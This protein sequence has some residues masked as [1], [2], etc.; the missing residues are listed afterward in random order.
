MPILRLLLTCLPLFIISMPALASVSSDLVMHNAPIIGT[1]IIVFFVLAYIFVLLEEKINL[2]KS[3]PVT[4]AAGA[5]WILVVFAYTQVG[6]QEE[7]IVLLRHSLLEYAELMLFLLAAMTYVNAMDD[8]G[9]FNALRVKLINTSLSLRSLF[10]ACGGIAFIL[11]PIADN[12]TTALILGAVC[13]AV[14]K[15]HPKFITLGMINIVV[16]ANAGGA[17]SPFGDITTLMVW[18]KGFV[19]FFS[20]FTLFIPSLISWVIPAYIM[21]LVIPK[22]VPRATKKIARIKY[23]GKTISLMFLMTIALTVTLHQQLHIPPFIGMMTGLGCLK[24]FGF[25]VRRYEL[26][27][28]PV[29]LAEDQEKPFDIFV[30]L[31]NIEWDT[32]IFFYGIMMCIGGLGAMGYMTSWSGMLYDN[33]GNTPTHI[34]VG[35]LSAILGNIPVMFAFLSMEHTHPIGQWLLMT[36]TAGIGGS[37]LSIGSAAGVALM[38]QAQGTYTFFSHLKWSWAIMLGYAAGV[39]AHLI[40]NAGVM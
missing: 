29:L 11:S 27:H 18:Q 39:G 31:K 16:A 32:L 13:L 35:F 9:M 34:L 38:G 22:T 17:F 3:K 25:F 40:I 24:I 15:G 23:G 8:R 33:L 10:W 7:A 37:L 20:F 4:V 26:R 36:L 19:D 6:R 14:G 5:I 1:F 30:S 2:R 12:L 21:S 28:R